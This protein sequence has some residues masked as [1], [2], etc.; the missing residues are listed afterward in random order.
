MTTK[1]EPITFRKT[2]RVV[3]V[4]YLAGFVVGIA[5]NL[6]IQSVLGGPN[7]LSMLSANSMPV[8]LGAI[9]WLLAVVGDAAHGVLMFPVLKPHS[10]RIAVSYLAARIADAMFIAIMVLL[11]LIQIP[12]ANEYLKTASPDA[13]H[14][15][16]ISSV[17][18]QAQQYTYEFGMIALGLSGLL[19]CT[20]LYRA[21]LVPRWLAIWGLDRQGL[22]FFGHRCQAIQHQFDRRVG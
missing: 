4:V 7:R 13:F 21:K 17:A 5:G 8:A 18:I 2:A 19:L 12:L 20:A 16:A 14:L 1:I 11:A 10:E 22:Q 9:L 6:L 3:G 15:Q